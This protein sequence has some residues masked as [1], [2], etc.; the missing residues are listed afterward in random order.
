MP[1]LTATAT[2]DDVMAPA[3]LSIGNYPN[4]FNPETTIRFALPASGLVK[5][6]VYNVR[7]QKVR[8]L[9]N[10]TCP[11]GVQ[12]VVFNGRDDACNTLASGVYLYRLEA[13]G[14]SITNKMLLVK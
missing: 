14:K 11:Q 8:T 2:S 5:L 3:K 4:P 10:D 13:A 1:E 12:S 9:V 7:G 6:S